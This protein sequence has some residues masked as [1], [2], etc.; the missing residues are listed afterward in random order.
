MDDAD[1]LCTRRYDVCDDDGGGG[2]RS[3]IVSVKRD[4]SEVCINLETDNAYVPVATITEIQC[5]L[6]GAFSG[7]AMIT[8]RKDKSCVYIDGGNFYEFTIDATINEFYGGAQYPV[9]IS[10]S[11]VYLP[12]LRKKIERR[13]YYPHTDWAGGGAHVAYYGNWGL[14]LRRSREEFEYYQ[15]AIDIDV[16]PCE[17]DYPNL[18]QYLQECDTYAFLN[19]G[20]EQFSQDMR[21]KDM[22]N[23]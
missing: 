21:T 12:S 7:S 8:C 11:Y 6:M 2:T 4:Y 9:A 17:L 14:M 3:L 19:P 16:P 10:D 18:E 13:H 22:L 5:V 20:L 23:D 1:I 15:H